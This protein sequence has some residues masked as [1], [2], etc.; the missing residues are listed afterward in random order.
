MP[1]WMFDLLDVWLDAPT[2]KEKKGFARNFALVIFAL[3]VA[4]FV[5]NI[6]G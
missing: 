6:A 3:A 4:V 2:G 5:A 1:S